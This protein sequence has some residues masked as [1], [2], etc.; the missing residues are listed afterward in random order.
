MGRHRLASG[1]DQ[2]TQIANRQLERKVNRFENDGE[3]YPPASR[4]ANESTC[5]TSLIVVSCLESIQ[6]GTH[7]IAHRR[8]TM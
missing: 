3:E 4:T 1:L 8:I 6:S 2:A 5:T 7:I